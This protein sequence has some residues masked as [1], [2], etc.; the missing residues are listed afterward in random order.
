MRPNFHPHSFGKKDPTKYL[1]TPG[2]SL[3]IVQS[4]HTNYFIPT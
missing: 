2:G 3:D 4:K 1:D